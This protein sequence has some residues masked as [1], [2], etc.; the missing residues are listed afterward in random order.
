M[1]STTVY[2]D[3]DADDQQIRPP[4]RS[5]D[6]GFVW[7]N[8][9]VG[10]ETDS[11]VNISPNSL[12]A[13]HGHGVVLQLGALDAAMG[14]VG[15]GQDAV[16]GPASVEQALRI[17]YEA[18]RKTYGARHDLLVRGSRDGAEPE[19]RIIVDNREYQRTLSRLQYLCSTAARMGQGVRIR[20]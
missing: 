19:Y 2:F 3:H 13:L 6:A 16:F 20:A 1:A 4:F 5:G 17:F 12:H 14:E 15:N 7:S 8:Q 18:D 10:F 11:Q 9:D